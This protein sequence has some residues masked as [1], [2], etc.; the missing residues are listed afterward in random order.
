MAVLDTDSKK[1]NH[2]TSS[3]SSLLLILLMFIS[4]H[5]MYEYM[6]FPSNV[7]SNTAVQGGTRCILFVLAKICFSCNFFAEKLNASPADSSQ[8]T[9]QSSSP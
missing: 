8:H 5:F 7:V 6:L 9:H 1:T 3:R 4:C 2:E